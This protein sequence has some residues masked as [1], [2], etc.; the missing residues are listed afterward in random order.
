VA[1]RIVLGVI[2]NS[3]HWNPI[4]RFYSKKA[5]DMTGESVKRIKKAPEK[6]S[7]LQNKKITV[8]KEGIPT[9]LEIVE[10]PKLLKDMIRFYKD[11]QKH[12]GK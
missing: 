3:C 11:P 1:N 8:V 2:H 10:D 4:V 9:P 6:P 12:S 5:I 7:S